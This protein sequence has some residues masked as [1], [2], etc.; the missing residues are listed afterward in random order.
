MRWD[1]ELGIWYLIEDHWLKIH[2]TTPRNADAWTLSVDFGE[3]VFEIGIDVRDW[4]ADFMVWPRRKPYILT[5][6][7]H[8]MHRKYAFAYYC[9]CTCQQNKKE[10]PGRKKS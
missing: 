9:P 1:R 5:I 8:R 10:K 2:G 3:C 6:G 4:Y 7:K